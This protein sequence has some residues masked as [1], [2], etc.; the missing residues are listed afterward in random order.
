[1]CSFIVKC[2]YFQPKVVKICY[3]TSKHVNQQKLIVHGR[4]K[5][6]EWFTFFHHVSKGMKTFVLEHL[7]L[8]L[9]I[10]QI[11]AKHRRHVKEIT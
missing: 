2:F 9:S 11:I 10:S 3:A 6:G 4:Y 5:L 8:G 7:H 1:M